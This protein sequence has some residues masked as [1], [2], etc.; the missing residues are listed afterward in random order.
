[1]TLVDPPAGSFVLYS[2]GYQQ[3]ALDRLSDTDEE[4]TSVYTRVL[5]KRLLEPG[6]QLAVLALRR[7]C[8]E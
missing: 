2:A 1:L 3:S 8:S 6:V 4:P 7:A 5:T